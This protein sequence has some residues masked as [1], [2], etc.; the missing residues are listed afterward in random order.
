M[1]TDF[2]DLG[3]N[4]RSML[5]MGSIRSHQN[6]RITRLN[7]KTQKLEHLCVSLCTFLS[8]PPQQ[9]VAY[10]KYFTAHVTASLLVYAN[11]EGGSPPSQ[12]YIQFLAVVKNEYY[13]FLIVSCTNLFLPKNA[14]V[15][16][17]ADFWCLPSAS[18]RYRRR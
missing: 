4:L 11:H 3:K 14:H 6:V 7:E 10:N 2:N 18:Q 12:T 8:P 1:R 13:S 5:C 15:S 9:V 17:L 16:S